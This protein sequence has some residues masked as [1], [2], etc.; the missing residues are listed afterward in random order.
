MQATFKSSLLILLFGVLSA[1]GGDDE[2]SQPSFESTLAESQF[3]NGGWTFSN[4]T[5]KYN[6]Y[7]AD[8]STWTQQKLTTDA[9]TLTLLDNGLSGSTT[10]KSLSDGTTTY[11]TEGET[12]DGFIVGDAITITGHIDGTTAALLLTMDNGMTASLI[13][14]VYDGGIVANDENQWVSLDYWDGVGVVSVEGSIAGSD[15]YVS[16][17]TYDETL[18]VTTTPS[19][20]EVPLGSGP[21]SYVNGTYTGS[22]YTYMSFDNN[23]WTY[24]DVEYNVTLTL[25]NDT[26]TG[27]LTLTSLDD[28]PSVDGY[29]VGD[30]FEV[31]G[32]VKGEVVY[33]NCTDPENPD[34]SWKHIVGN[35]Y[36]N[37]RSTLE[38]VGMFTTI[39]SYYGVT[40]RTE[41]TWG[42]ENEWELTLQVAE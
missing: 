33:L 42:G 34:F 24:E 32:V 1:C 30:T 20:V 4:I 10:L 29:G 15:S 36:V 14:S 22:G 31:N 35:Q 5:F 25:N 23:G 28:T 27:T 41:S 38:E 16:E 8:D 26:V 19:A 39:E 6:T 17:P 18:A 13:G 2:T 11:S 3:I 40:Y 37:S 12:L 9:G 21:S 7:S